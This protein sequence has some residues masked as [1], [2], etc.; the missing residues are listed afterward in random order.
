MLHG[1]EWSRGHGSGHLQ[2]VTGSWLRRA[3]VPADDHAGVVMG[4]GGSGHRGNVVTATPESVRGPGRQKA[5]GTELDRAGPGG[6]QTALLAVAW[7]MVRSV[8]IRYGT[9][10]AGTVPQEG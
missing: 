7:T 4:V 5:T 2:V 6:D 8:S 3:G 10:R 9:D 1:R